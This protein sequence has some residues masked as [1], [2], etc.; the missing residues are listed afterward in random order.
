MTHK[1]VVILL[2]LLVLAGLGYVAYITEPGP[3]ICDEPFP[4]DRLRREGHHEI[5]PRGYPTIRDR[6][7]AAHCRRGNQEDWTNWNNETYQLER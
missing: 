2:V 7:V 1:Y 6:W 3:F 5:V 4:R